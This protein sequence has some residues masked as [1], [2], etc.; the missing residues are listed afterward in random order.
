MSNYISFDIGGTAVKYGVIDDAGIIY[1]KGSF[2][3]PDNF[4]GLLDAMKMVLSTYQHKYS[5]VAIALSIPGAVNEVSGF[6]GGITA[7]RYIHGFNIK[8][9][10]SE[11]FGLPV[12]MANDANCAVLSEGWIGAAK[13][14]K[15]YA[16]V[17]IGT[18]VGGGVVVN[19]H[20]VS[21][22]TQHGGEFGYWIMD[23]FSRTNWSDL[24]STRIL[25][26]KAA[27]ALGVD[28]IDGEAFFALVANGNPLMIS[29]LDEFCFINALGIYNIKH[30][31]D[32]DLILVGGGISC[33]P[34]VIEGIN[35]QLKILL[36]RGG[37][38]EFEVVACHHRNDANLIG[39]VY[40]MLLKD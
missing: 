15:S 8:A 7:L 19:D 9:K 35:N 38:M 6:I 14:V 4:H 32:P 24:G 26:R 13:D 18:G 21:G 37:N 20:L 17:V 28:T 39:A 23:P 22:A 16:C 3:T 31:I 30:A 1:E 33:Q 34:K 2:P 10:F 12:G 5:P 27:W 40:N 29:L 36:S 11:V 25:L